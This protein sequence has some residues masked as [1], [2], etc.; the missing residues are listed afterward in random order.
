MYCV[1]MCT[2]S[3]SPTQRQI[4]LVRLHRVVEDALSEVRRLDDDVGLGEAPVEVAAAEL[5]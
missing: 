4:G 2:S 3:V 5:A 1:E